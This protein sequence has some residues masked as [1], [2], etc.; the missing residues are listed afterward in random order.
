M[1][2]QKWEYKFHKNYYGWSMFEDIT[3]LPT[4]CLTFSK[5]FWR[6]WYKRYMHHSLHKKGICVELCIFQHLFMYNLYEKTSKKVKSWRKLETFAILPN[7]NLKNF[8]SYLYGSK[9]EWKVFFVY[10]PYIY[11][12]RLALKLSIH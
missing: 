9:F 2:I 1:K 10:K 3:H 8:V 11:I 12:I 4:Y 6:T 5:C 7:H